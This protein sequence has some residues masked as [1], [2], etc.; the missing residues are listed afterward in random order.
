[1][2]FLQSAPEGFGAAIESLNLF[3]PNLL[4]QLA[5]ETLDF[6]QYKVNEVSLLLYDKNLQ[7]INIHLSQEQIQAGINAVTFIFRGSVKNNVEQN[8]L[9]VA[10]QAFTPI[11]KNLAEVLCRAWAKV[12]KQLQSS[13]IK[14]LLNIGQLVDIQWK[15]GVSFQSS[16]CKNLNSPYVSVLVI[17][18]DSNG[19]LSTHSFELTIPEFQNFASNFKDIANVMEPY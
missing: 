17:T 16:V 5:Q 13:P 8:D 3:P 1:M 9:Q 6:L 2:A 12:G 18:A 4:Y 11:D 10:L 14:Q 15:I 7:A 19:H